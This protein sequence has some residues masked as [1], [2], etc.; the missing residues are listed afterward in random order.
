[1]PAAGARR[2]APVRRRRDLVEIELAGPITALMTR[3]MLRGIKSRVQA[4]L[5]HY[6]VDIDGDAN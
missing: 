4:P 1:L 5:E 2:R 3:G 6:V